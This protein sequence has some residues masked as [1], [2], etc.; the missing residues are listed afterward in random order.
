MSIRF[1]ESR[2]SDNSF[3]QFQSLIK[4]N[5]DAPSLNNL[6]GVEFGQPRVLQEMYGNAL[7]PY[8]RNSDRLATLLNHYASSVSSPSR[9]L[10]TATVNNI[11]SAYKYATGQ[12]HSEISVSFIMPRSMQ[13]YTFFDR[14]INLIMND[15]TQH[16]DLLDNYTCTMKIYKMER[17][18]GKKRF[19]TEDDL[20]P[21][22]RTGRNRDSKRGFY[23]EN[24]ITGVWCLADVFPY[25]LGQVE[26][27]S[28]Q[29]NYTT[30]NV[31][32][33]YRN[34]R[35]YPNNK[36]V[37]M[38][39]KNQDKKSPEKEYLDSL[40]KDAAKFFQNFDGN[41]TELFG[42]NFDFS[43]ASKVGNYNFDAAVFNQPPGTEPLN[44]FGPTLNR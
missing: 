40:G 18:G 3:T 20:I 22:Q 7:I 42:N 27:Q 5:K 33:Q 28:G 44:F 6:Y 21:E 24:D 36:N 14:W 12:S 23:Y 1:N 35:F 30:F 32:F 19:F 10:T 37:N 13:T 11:G 31:G 17:G 4:S 15:T 29:A 43:A 41:Y 16:V 38:S 34:F 39:T 26:M 2:F 25:N 9:N 8:G